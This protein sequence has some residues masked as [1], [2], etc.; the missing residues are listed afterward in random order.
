MQ[1]GRQVAQERA[2]CESVTR[3]PTAEGA[4]A[5]AKNQDKPAE[6]KKRKCGVWYHPWLGQGRSTLLDRQ[7]SLICDE[8]QSTSMHP[9]YAAEFGRPISISIA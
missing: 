7:T 2:A 6:A 5:T 8:D 9:A 1:A 3:T 4:K